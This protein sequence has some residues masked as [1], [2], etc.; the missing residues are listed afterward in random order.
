VCFI[1]SLLYKYYF[2]FRIYNRTT[3]NTKTKTCDLLKEK[4][5]THGHNLGKIRLL[6][7]IIETSITKFIELL[8]RGFKLKSLDFDDVKSEYG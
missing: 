8:S 2:I 5:R 6:N 1:H 3:N 7:K 4:K